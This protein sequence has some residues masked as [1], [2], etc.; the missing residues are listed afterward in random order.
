MGPR[1]CLPLDDLLAHSN[2]FLNRVMES[3]ESGQPV[4]E[5]ALKHFGAVEHD[6]PV[7]FKC[8]ANVS[9]MSSNRFWFQISSATRLV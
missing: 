9:S 6:Q 7:V 4:G 1:R 3:W 2:H 8:L 5:N